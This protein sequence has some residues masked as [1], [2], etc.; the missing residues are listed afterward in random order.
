LEIVDSRQL[1]ILG[2]GGGRKTKPQT[3]LKLRP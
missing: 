2:R 1:L 3:S